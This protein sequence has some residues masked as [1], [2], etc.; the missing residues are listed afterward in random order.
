[1]GTQSQ[2]GGRGNWR[3]HEKVTAA[4]PQKRKVRRYVLVGASR[5][6]VPFFQADL[7]AACAIRTV[8]IPVRGESTGCAKQLAANHAASHA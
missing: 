5:K 3:A 6:G 8:P 1:V 7:P 4:L 2:N